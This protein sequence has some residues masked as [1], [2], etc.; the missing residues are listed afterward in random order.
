MSVVSEACNSKHTFTRMH[1]G[2]PDAAA[3]NSKENMATNSKAPALAPDEPIDD[4]V[5][6]FSC[7]CV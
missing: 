6:A 3:A 2:A 5:C 1:S 7:M 4:L